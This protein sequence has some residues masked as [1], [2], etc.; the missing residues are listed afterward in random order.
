[1]AQWSLFAGSLPSGLASCATVA[2]N[3][4]VVALCGGWCSRWRRPGAVGSGRVPGGARVTLRRFLGVWRGVLCARCAC[5]VSSKE[6]YRGLNGFSMNTVGHPKSIAY[7]H[8]T[9]SGRWLLEV[10][11]RKRT[12]PVPVKLEVGQFSPG[13]LRALA[14]SPGRS[15][16]SAWAPDFIWPCES[17]ATPAMR[18]PI[19]EWRRLA[20]AL[21]RCMRN[22][23]GPSGKRPRRRIRSAWTGGGSSR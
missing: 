20:G 16:D 23:G 14:V 12:L 2:Q 3:V 8:G 13:P 1:M 4:A 6:P 19:A 7:S 17:F 18:K 10:H 22:L 21:C 9:C 5:R 11:R 15:E